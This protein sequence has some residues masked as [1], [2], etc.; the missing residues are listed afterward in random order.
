MNIKKL[1]LTNY[2]LPVLGFNSGAFGGL[3]RGGNDFVGLDRKRST[4]HAPNKAFNIVIA[5]DSGQCAPA[6]KEVSHAYRSFTRAGYEVDFVTTDGKQVQ[7]RESDL[8][9]PVNQWFAEDAT[10]QYKA[11]HTL[12][13]GKTMPGRYVAIYFAGSD[14]TLSENS[15]FQQL[16]EFIMNSNGVVAGFGNAKQAA[17]SFGMRGKQSES[18]SIPESTAVVSP[19]EY[20][21]AASEVVDVSHSAWVIHKGELTDSIPDVS[22]L[23]ECIVTQ[24]AQ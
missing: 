19:S 3:I 1:F 15:W 5:A 8:T 17:A 22:E 24:L 14:N 21:S 18:Y 9:D 11:Y 16:S 6:L 12:E 2:Q 4:K 13:V 20:G 10:A 7:F 23:G